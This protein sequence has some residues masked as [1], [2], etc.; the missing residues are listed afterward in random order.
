[1]NSPA[2]AGMGSVL[3]L[4]ICDFH[5][6]CLLNAAVNII[7]LVSVPPQFP[8]WSFVETLQTIVRV[9]PHGKLE[10]NH[11]VIEQIKHVVFYIPGNW[12]TGF[13]WKW[14]V[15]Y[16]ALIQFVVLCF[17]SFILKKKSMTGEFF[18]QVKK[19]DGISA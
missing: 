14:P 7:G 4:Q 12:Q 5:I 13:C 18:C 10:E 8:S 1:M 19:G 6:C 3:K 9:I 15:T 17:H 16:F 11:E 2:L